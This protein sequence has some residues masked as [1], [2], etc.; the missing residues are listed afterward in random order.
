MIYLKAPR[1]Y[2][3]LSRFEANLQKFACKEESG[4]LHGVVSANLDGSESD[5][6]TMTYRVTIS[7]AGG[8]YPLTRAADNMAGIQKQA[9]ANA[10]NARLQRTVPAPPAQLGSYGSVGYGGRGHSTGSR[11]VADERV[12]LFS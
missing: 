9:L 11:K 7:H 3:K 5:E 1:C 10:I 12:P 4:V 2:L 6:G 8:T